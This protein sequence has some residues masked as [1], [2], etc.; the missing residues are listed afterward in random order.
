MHP[1]RPIFKLRLQPSPP[2]QKVGGTYTHEAIRS[3]GHPPRLSKEDAL[4]TNGYKQWMF[5]V[6]RPKQQQS[7][8]STGTR[9]KTNVGLPYMRGTSEA[10]TRVF[11]AHGVGTYHRPIN[12]IRSILVHPKDKTPDAQKCGLVYQVECPECLLTYIGETGRMLATRMKDHLN[13]RNPLTAVGEHCAHEHHTI[14]K[15]SVSIL[16]REDRK[17]REAIEIKIGQPAMNRDQGY[18]LPPHLR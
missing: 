13:L 2:T 5:K 12:T 6:P 11:K 3:H 7:T 4:K 8:T 16:A 18:E 14:T 10:L 1:H 17:V 15:D 9:P